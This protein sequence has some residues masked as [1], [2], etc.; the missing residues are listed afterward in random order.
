MKV[1]V[2]ASHPD[3][4]VLGAGG[5]IAKHV[6]NNDEVF[7]LILTK[8]RVPSEHIV[9]ASEALGVTNLTTL[10]FKAQEFQSNE[11]LIADCIRTHLEE[12]QP[13]IVYTHSINDLNLDHKIA[14]TATLIA[15]RA[16][17]QYSP[18]AVYAYEVMGSNM[19]PFTPFMGTHFV[20]VEPYM[21]TKIKA[22]EC[23]EK[24][25]NKYPQPRSIGGILIYAEGNGLKCGLKYAEAFETIFTLDV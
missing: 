16:N 6:Q 24:E 9:N 23:Y 11:H 15:T 2:I 12:V 14:H 5:T 18:N 7:I 25:M 17:L 8:G 4:E 20:D 19:T 21:D 13:D 3:D 1:L 10:N 22:M